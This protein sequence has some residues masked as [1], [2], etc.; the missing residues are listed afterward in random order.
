MRHEVL[1]FAETCDVCQKIK[2]DRRKKAGLLRSLP[3]PARPFH[4]IT[5]D[6][7]TG[8]SLSGG[9]DAILVFTDKLSKY[10]IFI[11]TNG[12]LSKMGFTRL[13]VEHIVCKFGMPEVLVCDRDG[14]W[15]SDF[16]RAV[17]QFL[18]IR[19]ALSTACHPQTDGQTERINQTLEIALRAYTALK[20]ESWSDWLPM[21]AHAYNTTVHSSTGFSPSS[22]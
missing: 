17:A 4:T 20:K 19:M 1:K 22:S 15:T 21:L 13:F 16:W 12:D 3:I 10:V 2:P 7:I 14:R 8:L 9:Y 18:R 5:M 11:P 6:L